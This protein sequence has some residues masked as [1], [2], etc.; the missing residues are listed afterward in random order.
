MPVAALC[1]SLLGL[2]SIAAVDAPAAKQ[3]QFL[4]LGVAIMAGFQLV[5]Y[6]ALLALAWPIYVGGLVLVAYT[7]LD[8]FI[9]VPLVKEVNGARNWIRLPLLSIQPAELVKAG[10]VMV[11]AGHLRFRETQ[12]TLRGLAVPAAMAV[13]PMLLILRQPDLG[14]ALVF[15]PTLAAVL[16]A[17][18]ARVRHLALA[19]GALLMLAP[20]AWLAGTEAP[21][22]RH[23]PAL[24][25]TYQRDRVLA[26]FRDDEQ[27]LQGVGYQQQWA[28]A[29]VGTG[30][31]IGK[32]PGD[33]PAGRLVPEAHNDMIFA[34]IGEQ[35]GLI[36]CG[37]TLLLY[38]TLCGGGLLIALSTREPFGRLIAVGTV[39]LI[40]GQAT[41]NI[42]VA[43]KIM[44]VT[45][46]TLPF[47]SYGGSS[48]LVSYMLVGLLL[49]V[50]QHRP[51]TLGRDPFDFDGKD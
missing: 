50:G 40:A 20:I 13:G 24:I 44:P 12:R 31:L 47:V 46:V 26:M 27:T 19:A 41:L 3:A 4:V 23:L 1:L 42:A 49:N 28:G 36:G 8:R 16:F 11:L 21:G 10:F 37:L 18:G 32:G 14:T 9:D 43:L 51:W 48:L 17:A 2:V 33:V 22:F 5:H 39:A 15:L 30:G 6:K 38:A 34:L 45:G 25:K 7:V 35:F 29:A